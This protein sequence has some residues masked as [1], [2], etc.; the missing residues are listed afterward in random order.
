MNV[1]ARRALGTRSGCGSSRHAI[2]GASLAL[3]M[4]VPAAGQVTRR[5]SVGPGGAQ[6]TWISQGQAI[7]ADGRYVIFRSGAN[8]L[9]A[10]DAGP[11]SDVFV[12]D[13]RTG[14]NDRVSVDSAGVQGDDESG[15]GVLGISADGRFVAFD[16]LA[17]NL[18]PG[19]T[20]GL[21]DVFFHDRQTGATERVSV[22]SAG[23]EGDGT[24]LY[25]T[26]SADGRY[27]A[28]TSE[29]TNLV[30]GDTNA[31]RDIFVRDRL[32]GTTER[33]SVDSAGVQ[34]DN[35]S[36]P[37]AL[38]SADGRYV[39]FLSGASNLVSGDTNHEWDVFVH[40]RQS[41]TT[42]RV[43]V[44]SAGA[45]G[46]GFCVGLSISPDCRY[47]AFGS[48]ATNLV[49]GWDGAYRFH[50]Y[51]HDRVSGTTERVD[52]DSAG[53]AALGSSYAPSIS[54]DGRYVAF[55]S[56]AYNLVPGDTNNR[57]DIFVRDRQTGR[58]VRA[59]LDSASV[60]GDD[61]SRFPYVSADGR[62]VAFESDATNLVPGDT[63]GYTDVFVRDLRADSFT[64]LCDPGLAGVIACPCSNPPGSPGRGCDNSSGTGGA[65]LSASGGAYLATDSLVFTTHGEKPTA[66]S[67]LL[68]GG[69]RISAGVVYGQGARCVGGSL[70]RLFTKTASGG[71]VTA[72]ELGAGDPAVS[73]RSAAL[74]DVI[75]P[76][77][78]RWYLVYYRDPTVLGGCPAGSTF[79][80]TQ[81]G[82]IAWY[83]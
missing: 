5:V 13:L 31:H 78:S 7:S 25:P 37:P 18:V 19:D 6:G 58:N 80:A 46:D 10:G 2:A 27:V 26:I 39:A 61:D 8:N 43:S 1:T 82:E 22:D 29:A 35:D 3:L 42:E 30:P 75:Q 54:S 77:Q 53:A 45:E 72:P 34:A 74:G 48:F 63:N 64:S 50:V 71:S 14:I 32:T 73:A 36:V 12:R 52:V 4:A 76:G 49:P 47:V 28:F 38:L 65:S 21:G 57:R 9:I 33:V 70:E 62:F 51:L 15:S 69:A 44:D 24:S 60:Q 55:D 16:S 11:W 40:D 81:T 17:T 79:N 56:D 59:S 20:N 41:G 67:I 83:P 66:T 68:Q 23:A